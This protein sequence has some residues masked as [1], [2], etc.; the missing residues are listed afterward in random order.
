MDGLK[1]QT[2]NVFAAPPPP[3]QQNHKAYKASMKLLTLGEIFLAHPPHL[4]G[5]VE[6]PCQASLL[7]SLGLK[8]AMEMGTPCF[9]PEHPPNKSQPRKQCLPG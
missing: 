6:C 9:Y 8:R 3:A 1:Q 2:N 5:V 7:L 4:L